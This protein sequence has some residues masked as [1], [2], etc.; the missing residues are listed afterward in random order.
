MA[1]GGFNRDIQKNVSLFGGI[2]LK[3]NFELSH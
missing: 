3:V 2:N 1:V